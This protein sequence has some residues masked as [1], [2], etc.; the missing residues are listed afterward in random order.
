MRIKDILRDPKK[1]FF[2]IGM[3]GGLKFLSDKCYLKLIY[4][5]NIG[6]KLNLDNPA[7]YNEKIQWLKLHDRKPE[8]TMMVDKYEVKKYV[9]NCIGKDKVIPTIGIYNSWKEINFEE[10]PEQFVIKCTHDSGGVCICKNKQEFNFEMAKKKINK[11]LKRNFYYTGREWPYKNVKPRIIIEQYME[12][13]SGYE[14]K[15]YKFFC[16]NGNVEMMFLA[17]DRNAKTETCF[18]FFDKEFNHLNIINGHPNTTKKITKPENYD[19]M[20]ELAEKLSKNI[21]HVR[22]DFYNINGKIYFGEMTFYHF[23]G[24]IKF[25]PEEWDYKFGELIKLPKD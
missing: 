25:E 17:T 16:F 12:D 3:H 2:S 18:D 11:L 15:D 22:I 9:E 8:Y 23:S 13:E 6:K 1:I 19:L 10:L 14:L 20:I 4:W 24:F 21:P 7:T 5:S